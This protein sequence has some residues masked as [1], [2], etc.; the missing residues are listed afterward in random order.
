MEVSDLIR[1]EDKKTCH[2][3]SPRAAEGC[4]IEHL[5]NAPSH[6][7]QVVAEQEKNIRVQD[8]EAAPHFG[9]DLAG[10]RLNE[11]IIN[12]KGVSESPSKLM[13]CSAVLPHMTRTLVLPLS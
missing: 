13:L 5:L 7:N 8:Y 3:P 12:Q 10:T 6:H 11:A 2:Q 1:E 9:A 4:R